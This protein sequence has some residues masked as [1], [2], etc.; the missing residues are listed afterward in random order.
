MITLLLGPFQT[1][2]KSNFYNLP[3]WSST[4]IWCPNFCDIRD[5]PDRDTVT[6]GDSTVH[7]VYT[8]TLVHLHME[9]SNFLAVYTSYILAHVRDIHCTSPCCLLSNNRSIVLPVYRP[10]PFR[11]DHLVHSMN[12][13]SLWSDQSTRQLNHSRPHPHDY[14]QSEQGTDVSIEAVDMHPG[15]R[16]LI[17][18]ELKTRN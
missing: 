18:V 6:R 8:D 11:F 1:S 15:S 9:K 17:F 12:H 10:Y 14:C 4:C 2:E 3:S 5:Q 13:L 7:I 16:F